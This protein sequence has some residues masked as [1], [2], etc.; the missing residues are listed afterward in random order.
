LFDDYQTIGDCH[1]DKILKGR[2]T[3]NQL[4]QENRS[5]V[6]MEEKALQELKALI[7]RQG[8]NRINR[9]AAPSTQTEKPVYF[10]R[11]VEKTI[12]ILN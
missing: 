12:L 11:Y 9:S 4:N 1:L 5:S 6:F 10:D 8:D 7:L 2:V 3:M